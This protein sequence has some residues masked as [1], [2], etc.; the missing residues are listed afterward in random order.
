LD[1]L[2]RQRHVPPCSKLEL[3]HRLLDFILEME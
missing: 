3:A 1:R 2:G